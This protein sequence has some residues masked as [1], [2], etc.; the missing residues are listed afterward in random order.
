MRWISAL[1]ILALL[2]TMLEVQN[3]SVAFDVD[4]GTVQ[5]VR[6]ISFSV[7]PA[8]TLAIVG[9]SGCGK[10]VA[11]QS[12]MG[13]IPSPPGRIRSGSAMFEGYDLL[14]LT[15]LQ[16]ATINGKRIGMIFQDPMAALNPTMRIGDQIGEALVVHKRISQRQAQHHAEKLLEDVRI[17]APATRLRQYPHTYSGGMLQRAMIAMALA[18]RPALLI[19]DEPTTALDVTIQ[20]QILSLLDEL[21]HE[22][23][24]A[25]ILITHDLGVVAQMADQVAVMYAGEIVEQGSVTAI[26]DRPA[27]PYTLGLKQA[28]PAR[29]AKVKTSLKPIQG[30]PPDL[31]HPPSGCAYAARCPYTMKICE[32]QPPPK[33]V[34]PAPQST[35]AIGDETQSVKCW[36]HHDNAP[37]NLTPL[38]L[39]PA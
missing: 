37:S 18:T 2:R 3:L 26:F 24:M 8:T 25:M 32:Q 27:H 36:L 13:L 17:P 20:A 7:Q 33:F 6:G 35:S 9:E 14:N 34:L 22:Q 5:A 15:P 38:N 28:M 23:A 16:R 31:Y 30:S 12:L 19:A 10:S 29:T 11:M 21:K 4:G 39:R 1:V